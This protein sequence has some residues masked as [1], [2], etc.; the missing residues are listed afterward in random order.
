M[1]KNGFIPKL[2]TK[3][4]LWVQ[5]FAN[6]GTFNA[7]LG[8]VFM[9]WFLVK[10]NHSNNSNKLYLIIVPYLVNENIFQI[11]YTKIHYTNH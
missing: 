7:I 6:Y 10:C 1:D 2:V 11:V 5:K 3:I 8:H 9:W 4:A